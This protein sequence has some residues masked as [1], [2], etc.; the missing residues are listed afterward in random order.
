MTLHII[1]RSVFYL[2]HDVRETAFCLRLQ[3]QST[4]LDARESATDGDRTVDN[5]EN[6][7]SYAN[8]KA[9]LPV[10]FII[11]SFFASF[12]PRYYPE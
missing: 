5:V 9:P 8:Y 12:E 11:P 4:Q 6:C 3:L 1:F 7:G 2:K 10:I